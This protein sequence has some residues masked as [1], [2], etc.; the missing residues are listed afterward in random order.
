MCISCW[1]CVHRCKDIQHWITGAVLKSLLFM[2]CRW[3]MDIGEMVS[4]GSVSHTE[5]NQYLFQV[6]LSS[7]SYTATPPP[8]SLPPELCFCLPVLTLSY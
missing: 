6:I 4:Y 8:S 7:F 5:I 3:R 2:I 1:C